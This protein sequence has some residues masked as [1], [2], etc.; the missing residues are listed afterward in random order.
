MCPP[1]CT[2]RGT[3]GRSSSSPGP[4]FTADRFTRAPEAHAPTPAWPFARQRVEVGQV[5]PWRPPRR[6]LLA[7]LAS[8]AFHRPLRDP[9]RGSDLQALRPTLKASN[10]LEP[11]PLPTIKLSRG[12]RGCPT[13][14]PKA[15]SSKRTP[16]RRER[17]SVVSFAR[18]RGIIPMTAVLGT[19]KS[20][21]VKVSCWSA[22][23]RSS[24][25]MRIVSRVRQVPAGL[26][27]RVP[28]GG[29]CAVATGSRVRTVGGEPARQALRPR[30]G[31]QSAGAAAPRCRLSRGSPRPRSARADSG[32]RP[33][34]G[35][36]EADPFMNR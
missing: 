26:R 35:G 30:N 32:T 7:P 15:G 2:R 3:A 28:G 10:S 8:P 34:E 23:R 33:R 19:V 27:G 11:D 20:L 25:S 22:W 12:G 21:S 13:A 14:I 5:S 36:S 16:A 1:R 24:P 4:G 31:R 6:G 9:Q 18:I 29:H 17:P